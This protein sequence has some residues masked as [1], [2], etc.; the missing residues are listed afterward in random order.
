MIL[1]WILTSYVFF[2]L[3]FYVLLEVFSVTEVQKGLALILIN[4][5]QGIQSNK[6]L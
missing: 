5:I 2:G 4:I 1:I 6:I 3:L